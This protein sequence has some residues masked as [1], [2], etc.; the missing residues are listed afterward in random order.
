M[1]GSLGRAGDAAGVM[2]TKL[3]MMMLR[4][5][6]RSHPQAPSQ[7]VPLAPNLAAAIVLVTV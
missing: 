2:V 1:K 7:T 4:L 5:P 3:G 6:W